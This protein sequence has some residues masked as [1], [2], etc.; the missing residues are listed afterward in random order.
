MIMIQTGKKFGGNFP[1]INDRS[2]FSLFN[3]SFAFLP[4]WIECTF[5]P[6]LTQVWWTIFGC[7]IITFITECFLEWSGK[8]EERK[9]KVR[10]EKKKEESKGWKEERKLG[11]KR[12]KEKVRDGKKRYYVTICRLQIMVTVIV[13]MCYKW[14][15]ILYT[16][17][18]DHTLIQVLSFQSVLS[19]NRKVN[20]TILFFH[21]ME[22]ETNLCN[23]LMEEEIDEWPEVSD[24][25]LLPLLPPSICFP[26]PSVKSSCENLAESLMNGSRKSS[27]LGWWWWW[28]E[29]GGRTE[30][31]DGVTSGVGVENRRP[32]PPDLLPVPPFTWV[33][34]SKLD[35]SRRGKWRVGLR[36]LRWEEGSKSS[37]ICGSESRPPAEGGTEYDSDGRWCS[38]RDE[39]DPGWCWEAGLGPWNSTRPGLWP[40]FLR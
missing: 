14:I 36:C 34:S 7:I 8:Q 19:F 15:C 12:R 30:D 37:S 2:T 17:P 25:F 21:H 23:S 4:S 13:I 35:L 31:V 29:D 27:L 6:Q 9:R 26:L 40:H 24:F 28:I 16:I 33:P 22:R 11:W 32:L 38:W 1:L 39:E 3:I 18:F 20:H 10:D 5:P